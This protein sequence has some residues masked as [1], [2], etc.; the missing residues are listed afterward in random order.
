[1]EGPKCELK[2]SLVF[3]VG[4][5]D[6]RTEMMYT[7]SRNHSQVSLAFGDVCNPRDSLPRKER[8]AFVLAFPKALKRLGG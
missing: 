2:P 5:L 8:I 1:M 6:F 3:S 7:Y 4:T